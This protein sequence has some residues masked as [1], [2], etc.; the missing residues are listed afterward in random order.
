MVDAFILVV[1]PGKLPCGSNRAACVSL[2]FRR[3]ALNLE[4]NK[5]VARH[6]G[7]EHFLNLVEVVIR[8]VQI[9]LLKLIEAFLFP[10]HIN[11]FG[12]AR[13]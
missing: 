10:E 1:W 3:I 5:R 8:D 12:A 7:K 13:V 9:D 11:L 2:Q 4:Y 6:S